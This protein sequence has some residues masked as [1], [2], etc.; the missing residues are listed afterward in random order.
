MSFTYLYFT[1]LNIAKFTP[2][3]IAENKAFFSVNERGIKR[4]KKYERNRIK[5]NTPFEV[6]QHSRGER[7][8]NESLYIAEYLINEVD[9]F[10]G[11]DLDLMPYIGKHL[12][13]KKFDKGKL[14]IKKGDEAD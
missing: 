9:Y 6:C 4:L 10:S 5:G 2:P 7:N 14:I 1:Q 8:D 13:A 3:A 11:M 12:D